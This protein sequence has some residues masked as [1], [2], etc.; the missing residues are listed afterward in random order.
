[1]R[2]TNE[3]K[4]TNARFPF[5]NRFHLPNMESIDLDNKWITNRRHRHD[6]DRITREMR[7]DG[8]CNQ[9]CGKF[10]CV[11]VWI[12]FIVSQS[13]QKDKLID[14][15]DTCIGLTQKKQQRKTECDLKRVMQWQYADASWK[16]GLVVYSY[17]RISF[18]ID[19]THMSVQNVYVALAAI[20]RRKSCI[21]FA[22]DIV[23]RMAIELWCR[24]F[25]HLTFQ[26][27]FGIFFSFSRSRKKTHFITPKWENESTISMGS[28]WN[29]N[30]GI[31]IG[32]IWHDRASKS[33]HLIEIL[34]GFQTVIWIDVVRQSLWTIAPNS[35]LFMKNCRL[36]LSSIKRFWIVYA[37][38]WLSIDLTKNQRC[39]T[40]RIQTE[41]KER[42]AEKKRFLFFIYFE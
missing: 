17:G 37:L 35:F 31:F 26:S 24:A 11:C 18:L 27:E 8:A 15:L 28:K 36:I 32:F 21:W 23:D 10:K 30:N 6:R 41:E 2:T 29:R 42:R 38:S 39:R 3:R 13:V 9:F 5:L 34:F 33:E 22:F 1:M 16:L 25:G 4:T 12:G 14:S 19:M 20:I 40:Q 7:F